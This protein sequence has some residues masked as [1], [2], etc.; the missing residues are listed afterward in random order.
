MAF[1]LKK[2]ITIQGVIHCVTGLHIGGNKEEI[3]IG[4]MDNPVIRHPLTKEPYIPGSSLKGKLRALLEYKHGKVQNNG[5]PC[6]CATENCPVCR[7]FGPHKHPKHNLGPTRLLC[8]DAK[9]TDASREALTPLASEGLLYAELKSENIINRKT[10]TATDPRTQERVP[11]DTKFDFT[12]TLRVFEQDQEMELLQ[13]ITEGLTLLEADYL[14][15]SGSRGYGQI[16]LE[17]L[18]KDGQDIPNWREQGLA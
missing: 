8:R 5:D 1:K 12:L 6:N 15:G 7:I 3:E 4:G 18:K 14:G 17:Q 11:A 9:L 2:Y 10:G 16:K 13:R